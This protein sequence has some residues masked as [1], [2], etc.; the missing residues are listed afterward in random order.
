ML[1]RSLGLNSKAIV[2]GDVTQIDLPAG[3]MSGLVEGEHILKGIKGIS[4]T[5]FTDKDVVRHSLVQDI[6]NAYESVKSSRGKVRKKR[7]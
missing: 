4:F 6:I 5:Q 7:A 3:K 1:F 2:T